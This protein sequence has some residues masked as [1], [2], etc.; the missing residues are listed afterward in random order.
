MN[1][2]LLQPLEMLE[3][4]PIFQ[5]L[6]E[7][8]ENNILFSPWHAGKLG[9]P[10]FSS[11]PISVEYPSYSCISMYFFSCPKNHISM[12]KCYFFM[13]MGL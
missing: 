7:N 13:S 2:G 8:L 3:K 9:F 12:L 10:L 1:P 11:L 4:G 5:F 6:L